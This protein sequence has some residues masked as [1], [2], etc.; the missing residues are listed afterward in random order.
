MI[1]LRELNPDDV[2]EVRRIY[3]GPSLRYL[4]RGPMGVDEAAAYVAAATARPRLRYIFG[5]DVGGDLAGIIKL[6]TADSEARL[7]Y[8]LRHDTWGRGVATCAVTESLAFAFDA[9]SVST[10]RAKHRVENGASGRVLRKSGF[11]QTGTAGGFLY[12]MAVGCFREGSSPQ[13]SC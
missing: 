4:G 11:T 8:I 10:V 5:I 1:R 9:L 12:Y 13:A 7:S 6:N 2:S 3:S